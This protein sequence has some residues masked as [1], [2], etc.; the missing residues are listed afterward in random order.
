MG[1]D[2]QTGKIT[3]F[4]DAVGGLSGKFATLSSSI[5]MSRMTGLDMGVVVDQMGF[6]MKTMGDTSGQAVKTFA[7]LT[8]AANK[9][10]VS[11]SILLPNVRRLQEQ[12]KFLGIDAAKTTLTLGNAA[13]AARRAGLGPAAGVELMGRGI[14]GLQN[15]SFG[16][17][18]FLGQK[19][20]LGAGLS[21]GFQFREQLGTRGAEFARGTVG[22]A[23]Q[24]FGGRSVSLAEARTS[25]QAAALRLG[26]EQL[27]AQLMGVTQTEARGIIEMTD[28]LASLEASG[29]ATPEELEKVR[30]DL[31]KASM[32]EKDYAERTLTVQEKIAAYME[33]LTTTLSKVLLGFVRGV[34]G[35]AAGAMGLDNK[36]VQDFFTAMKQGKA[37]DVPMKAMMASLDNASPKLEAWATGFGESVGSLIGWVVKL[38][39]VIAVTYAG[40]IGIKIV[41]EFMALK[42]GAKKVAEAF[43]TTKEVVSAAKGAGEALSGA[44]KGASTLGKLFPTFGK[45]FSA[46]GGLFTKAFS[47]V[48]GLFTAALASFTAV[49]ARSAGTVFTSLGSAGLV[50][51]AAGLGVAFGLWARTWTWGDKTI[52]EHMDGFVANLRFGT[53][54]VAEQT[55]EINK[56]ILARAAETKKLEK[57]AGM[58]ASYAYQKTLGTG[59]VTG[60]GALG[61]ESAAGLKLRGQAVSESLRL[62]IGNDPKAFDRLAKFVEA[63]GGIGKVT[64]EQLGEELSNLSDVI[65]GQ[66]GANKQT[67]V[68]DIYKLLLQI[69][70]I[71]QAEKGPAA[72]KK[73]AW[74]VQKSGWLYASP[75][76]MIVD[77]QSLATAMRSGGR[78]SALGVGGAQ[79]NIFEGMRATTATGAK[80]SAGGGADTREH[81]VIFN[82]KAVSDKLGELVDARIAYNVERDIITAGKNGTSKLSKGSSNKGY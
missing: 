38:R 44:S 11:T 54:A 9:S 10:G 65:A 8:V 58:T 16:T 56:G 35:K 28:K 31:E 4:A 53:K 43:S 49:L 6:Q 78:G 24:M 32:S 17:Q 29:D 19:M 33:F 52:G 18:A 66:S 1:V 51:A 5:A 41:R 30:D 69:S 23:Q 73:D 34:A 3:T 46:V 68:F 45:A 77:S 62:S 39:N 15:A 50:G 13:I 57:A 60:A 67:S 71:K 27:V 64:S 36:A 74:D 48:G 14:G 59:M 82:I 47:A 76:D 22:G 2:E 12:F 63:Q 25:P 79:R 21:A 75:G 40:Y 37:I 55:A 26:Q 20:G 61:K 72:P 42:E 80:A 81:E 70:E 7:A